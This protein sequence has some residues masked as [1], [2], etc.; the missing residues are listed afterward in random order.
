MTQIDRVTPFQRLRLESQ[1]RLAV[2]VTSLILVPGVLWAVVDASV[3]PNP[4]VR[5]LLHAVR[6][7]HL[8]A[9]LVGIVLIRRAQSREAL[10]RVL[11]GLALTVVVFMA[12]NAFLRPGTDFMPMRTFILVSIGTFVVYPY[13]FRNQTIAWLALAATLVALLWLHYTGMSNV[14]RY[15]VLL[16]FLIAGALGMAVARNR[17]TLDRDLDDALEREREAIEARERAA[18]ALRTL[19]G[20]IPICAYC[21]QVRTEAGAWEKLDEYV[22]SR[23]DA[24]FSHGMCPSCAAQHFPEVFGPDAVNPIPTVPR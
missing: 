14:E 9:W 24:D 23:T 22:R 7:A 2:L 4:L 21:H 10:G 16:N 19:E 20:I 15:A 13:R 1:R 17:S 6:L 3:A 5:Q 11:F 12:A 18:A 8:L